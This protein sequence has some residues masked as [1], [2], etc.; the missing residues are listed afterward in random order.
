[1]TTTIS[2]EVAEPAKFTEVR[3]TRRRAAA[4]FRFVSFV[5]ILLCGLC[6]LCVDRCLYREAL[7]L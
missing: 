3:S 2:T 1:V 4:V 5:V 7:A 6:E